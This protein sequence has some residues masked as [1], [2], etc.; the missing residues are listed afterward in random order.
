MDMDVDSEGSRRMV[1]FRLY[2]DLHYEM[3]PSIADVPNIATVKRGKGADLI[4]IAGDLHPCADE[5][6]YKEALRKIFGDGSIPILYIPGNHEY[7]WFGDKLNESERNST[8]IDK[9]DSKMAKI[10]A[11]V[12]G[13][14]FQF[15]NGRN[16]DVGGV[17]FIGA[18]LWTNVPLNIQQG[19]LNDYQVI[20]GSLQSVLT[21]REVFQRHQ[22]QRNW[23]SDSIDNA[24]D[25]GVD[26]VVVITH[27]IPSERLANNCW[28]YKTKRNE[29][30]ACDTLV[31]D[32]KGE[33]MPYYY[34]SDMEESFSK[35]IVST[36]CFGHDHRSRIDQPFPRG[37]YFC[38]NALGYPGQYDPK[39]NKHLLLKV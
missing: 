30:S 37:P 32:T 13:D 27:H 3:Y 34:S 14:R 21:N 38:S 24:V 2:S 5:R 8:D 36:W 7:Y 12:G 17:R 25:Q 6:S 23:L 20:P 9:M 31:R 10:C 18:T 15:L 16:Y 22:I 11:E 4:V 19:P 26:K 35:P 28:S 33:Y 29:I 1:N 39:F